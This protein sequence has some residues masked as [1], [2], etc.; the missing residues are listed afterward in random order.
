MNN[1]KAWGCL[2]VV[3]LV[4]VNHSESQSTFISSFP[5]D[6]ERVWI[7][8]EYWS[9]PMEDWR[10]SQGRLECI[11]GRGNRN[12]HVL[13]RELSNQSGDFEIS[14]R[15]GLIEPGENDGSVGFR[16][17]IQDEIDDYRARCFRYAQ[18]IDAGITTEGKL[19]IANESQPI[20]PSPSFKAK[21]IQLKLTGKQEGKDYHLLL[22]AIDLITGRQI[23]SFR[24]NPIPPERLVGNIALVN[25]HAASLNNGPRFWF[26][27]WSITGAKIT[28]HDDHAFGPILWAMHTLSR[29]MMKMTAQM[30]PIGNNDSQTVKLQIQRTGEWNTIGE[31]KINSD[32]RTATFR[33]ADWDDSKDIPYRLVYSL[34]EGNGR[35]EDFF[36]DWNRA[37]RSG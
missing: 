3:L 4:S 1:V 10:I 37:Q 21:A 29:G 20:Q 31:E 33:I 25:N 22:T 13:T 28:T 16:I 24:S 27:D 34:N 7:G 9:N 5:K 23:S 30:P 32:S 19:F 2:F 12:V 11:S 17:G 35:T 14:V 26:A 8:R 15:L 18:G 6:T 36:L